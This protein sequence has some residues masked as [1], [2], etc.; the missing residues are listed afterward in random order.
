MLKHY[1]SNEIIKTILSEYELPLNGIHGITHWAR[2]MENGLRLAENNG[3]DSKITT[4]FAVFHDSKRQNE[5]RDDGHGKRGGEFAF[6]LKDT[7]INL[8]NDQFDL[9]YYACSY[10]TAGKTEGDLTVRTCWDS[11]RLDL[12]RVKIKTEPDRLCTNEAKQQEII[13]W[14]EK[15][16]GDRYSPSIVEIWKQHI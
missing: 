1:I 4:L 13:E 16:A 9:L 10:H 5:S 3:A 8:N 2:V 7:L 14:A 15:R 6:R 11:D 12:N